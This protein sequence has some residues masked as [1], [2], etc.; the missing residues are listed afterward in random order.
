M[1]GRRRRRRRRR[2]S[3]STFHFKSL[4]LKNCLITFFLFWHG[5]SLGRYQY[6]KIW[7][8]LNHPKGH[9]KGQKGQIW[10]FFHLEAIFSKTV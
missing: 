10:S 8:W 4:F 2:P 1:P 3:S 9:F 7:I 5:A 6:C